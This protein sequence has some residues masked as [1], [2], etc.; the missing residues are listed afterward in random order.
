M[1]RKAAKSSTGCSPTARRGVLLGEGG[2]DGELRESSE[3]RDLRVQQSK[4]RAIDSQTQLIRRITFRRMWTASRESRRRFC[5]LDAI[6]FRSETV[7]NHNFQMRSES[8]QL[9][10]DCLQVH[11]FELPKYVPPNDNRLIDDPIEQWLYFF[12]RA[13]QS[14]AEE[15]TARLADPVFAE[16]TGVLEMIA[17]NPDERRFYNERLKLERDERARNQQAREE[18]REEGRQEGEL[19][20]CVKILQKLNGDTPATTAELLRLGTEQLMVLEREL[21]QRLRERSS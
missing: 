19:V 9:L 6:E 3:T 1:L 2:I 21:Q 8:G 5:L 17:Q 16:A 11:L 18:G 20:G 13:E 7:L 12:R 4:R 14:T 15:L 10:T